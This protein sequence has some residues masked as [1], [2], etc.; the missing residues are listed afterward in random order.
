[1]NCDYVREVYGVP[2][3]I[4]RRVL[5]DGEPGII[6][7]DMGNHIGILLD[8]DKPTAINPYHPCHKIEYLGMGKVR[9]MTSSQ[10][11]YREYLE[12]S[13]CF[14]SFKHYLDY[15]NTYK[16]KLIAEAFDREKRF[17]EFCEMAEL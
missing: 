5:V 6:V 14:D 9:Q 17:N 7:K 8:K 16:A 15:L 1:M 10:K 11:R 13:D 12:Y 2:A 3:E 4:G